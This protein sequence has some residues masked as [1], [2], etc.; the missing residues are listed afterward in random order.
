MSIPDIFARCGEDEFRRLETEAIAQLG[1]R[2]GIII[3]TGGGCVTR[4]E[5]YP[6]LH[7]NSA[8]FWLKR[9]I[10]ALPTDG[11]PRSQTGKL[12]TMYEVRRPLYARFADH[13]IDNNGP[14]GDA[15]TAIKEALV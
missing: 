1:K 6:L 10:S 13:V 5:N 7:Q 3:A 12:E 9:D 8:I 4:A 2:S 11:R 15:V 14:L